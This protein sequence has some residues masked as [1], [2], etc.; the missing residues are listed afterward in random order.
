MLNLW[1]L[2]HISISILKCSYRLFSFLILLEILQNTSRR[3]ARSVVWCFINNSWEYTWCKCSTK[4]LMLGECIIVNW[5]W[6]WMTSK[7]T[8]LIFI[9]F[10]I[11]DIEVQNWF[12]MRSQLIGSNHLRLFQFNWNLQS[13]QES[14]DWCSF[15][16]I[17]YYWFCYLLITAF[18]L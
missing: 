16:L 5:F 2:H 13:F 15:I 7:I 10:K 11:P 9:L 12:F 14:L 3:Y 1:K 8:K 17:S 4:I 6:F 18:S